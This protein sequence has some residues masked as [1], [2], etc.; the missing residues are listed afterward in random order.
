MTALS[1]SYFGV[2]KNALQTLDESGMYCFSVSACLRVDTL[3]LTS[4]PIRNC[5]ICSGSCTQVIEQ[6]RLSGCIVHRHIGVM[7]LHVLLH[8]SWVD[9]MFWPDRG[10]SRT[11]IL[12]F[13]KIT[14]FRPL[15][16]PSRPEFYML[17]LHNQNGQVV[18]PE[19]SCRSVCLVFLSRRLPTLAQAIRRKLELTSSLSSHNSTD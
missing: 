7:M 4:R 5:S 19:S 9:A 18:A 17:L 11:V 6:D 14:V 13:L 3:L 1:S 2:L 15:Q 16:T 12:R 10:P 8:V